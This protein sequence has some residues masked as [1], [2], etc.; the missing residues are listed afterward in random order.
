MQPVYRTLT[1]LIL[2]LVFTGMRFGA[3]AQGTAGSAQP[4][5]N[6]T[7][8]GIEVVWDSLQ[9]PL[10]ISADLIP[11][12]IRAVNIYP[13][14]NVSA[15]DIDV[16]IQNAL[17]I[18]EVARISWTAEFFTG[19]S[20]KL[21][22]QVRYRKEG[23]TDLIKKG[24]ISSGNKNDFPVL[25][26]DLKSLIKF[27]L[28]GNLAPTLITNTWWGN[29]KTFTEFNPYGNDPPD[30]TASLNAEGYVFAG[31]AGIIRIKQGKV[32]LYAYGAV[33]TLSTVTYGGEL[34]N[35]HSNTFNF[36]IE[37]A[38]AGIVGT[39]TLDNGHLFR[40]N[41][42]FGKQPYR[43]GTG[44]LICQIS[45][46]G[47]TWGGMNAWPRFSG[48]LVGLVKIAYDNWKVEGFYIDPHEYW[49][50]DSKT[51]LGGFNAEYNRINGLSGGFTYLNVFDS[52]FPY[53]Y[54]D[55]TQG[56]RE[57]L[58]ALNLRLQ[59]M[60]RT[61]ESFLFGKA[62]GG[63]QVNN[64]TP[65]EAYGMAFEGGWS[66]GNAKWRPAVSYRYSKLTG[67][68]PDTET[69]ER[70]D[71]LYSGDDVFT[72]VQGL[73]M[74][75]ILFNTNMEVNKF[76]L[77]V[78]PK[79]WRITSQYLFFQANQLNTVPS[80]PVGTFTSKQIGQ[81]L[82]LVAERYVSRNIYLRFVFS[83]LWPGEGIAEVLPEPVSKPWME[84]QAMFRFS[85]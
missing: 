34:Y 77:Q 2:I 40:F 82:L 55:Y 72:W 29:G 83:S 71:F 85:F 54:P 81:E 80:P 65:M 20:V 56:S 12:I 53:F 69:I 16:S 70:W 6:M 51:R 49:K 33:N 36:Q 35:S 19:N 14:T 78:F 41:L 73:L 58:N 50:N 8:A 5:R 39:R 31:I 37:E 21:I 26:Q 15:F 22:L 1:A 42:S 74:K 57:G 28:A 11:K 23:K 59:W 3:F 4:D 64:K 24:I 75:N 10:E 44:M 63:Y 27:N 47:G 43:I 25:Y 38:Y 32:P 46:N 9:P 66:F 13:N 7:I 76:Q 30:T 48:E 18:P 62:E 67:D 79:G 61:N 60:P 17:R 52:E 45:G 68:D 84:Y